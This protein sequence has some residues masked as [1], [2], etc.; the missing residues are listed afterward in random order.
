MYPEEKAHLTPSEE[1]FAWRVK[2]LRKAMAADDFLYY[3]VVKR[4]EP[5]KLLAYAEW[6]TPGHFRSSNISDTYGNASIKTSAETD[7]TAQGVPE[8][9]STTDKTSNDL[10]ACMDVAIH[11]D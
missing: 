10:S 5:Q 11:K 2:R 1:L 8:A 6:Y 7:M 3:K 9:A 4:D